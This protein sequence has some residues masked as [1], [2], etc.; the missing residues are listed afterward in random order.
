MK[1]LISRF[2]RKPKVSVNPVKNCT[3]C[4]HNDGYRCTVGSYLAEQGKSGICYDGNLWEA[5]KQ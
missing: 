4:K 3:T 2:K 1:N 5:I